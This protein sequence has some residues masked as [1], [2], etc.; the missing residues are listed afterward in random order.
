[1]DGSV[2]VTSTGT[3]DTSKA[4]TYTITY[5]A[6]DT[7]GNT[8]TATR[9]VIVKEKSPPT[10]GGSSGG[11][12]GSGGGNSGGSG[13][14]GGAGSGG[15]GAGGGG[16]LIIPD[17]KIP[18]SGA[19]KGE[20][21]PAQKLNSQGISKADLSLEDID[22]ALYEIG[23]KAGAAATIG[24]NLGESKDAKGYLLNIPAKALKGKGRTRFDV[25]TPYGSILV[26]D[27]VLDYSVSDTAQV[28]IRIT[29]VDP[30]ELEPDLKSMI[31]NRPVIELA[32]WINGKPYAWNNSAVPV[33]VTLDYQPTGEELENHE[34]L[35]IIYFDGEG[36]AHA[37]PNGSYDPDTG[38]VTFSVTHFSRFAV[39]YVYKTFTDI[40]DSRVRNK[41][42]VMASKGIIGG[43]SATTYSPQAN[44]TRADFL[45][46]LF[47]AMGIELKATSNF[48]D[49]RPGIC[50]Y[51]AVGIAKAF[52]ITSGTGNN[53]FSPDAY[54]TRQ[55]MMVMAAK[56]LRIFNVLDKSADLSQLDKLRD[57][58]DIAGYARE[59]IA[60][61]TGEGLVPADP[62]FRPGSNT[63][64]EEVADMIYNIYFYMRK[65]GNGQE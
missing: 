48:D 6:T 11:G 63:S 44:I 12:S 25:K 51:D 2:A 1:M 16:S 52:G 50:Y 28:G 62:V 24:V 22:K 37:V 36:K 49:I 42:E 56:A 3:V 64:R 47:R 14:G 55:D 59:P 15:G 19:P 32:M 38:K 7:A 10:G 4:G 57:K 23:T 18:Q 17:E 9:K 43:T 21:T 45:Y 20:I 13:G 33:T 41:I 29:R 39:S 40:T 5:T 30:A 58:D 61:L 34:H 54:I 26:P 60:L 27:N 31:G 46:L 65:N 53:R 35:V 8:A